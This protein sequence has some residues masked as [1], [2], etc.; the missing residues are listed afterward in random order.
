MHR[1]YQIITFLILIA[2]ID[3]AIWSQKFDSKKDSLSALLKADVEDTIKVMHL[4]ELGWELMYQNPDTAIIIGNQ[5]VELANSISEDKMAQ[6]NPTFKKSAYRLLAKSNNYLGI[7]YWVKGE[8]VT[9]LATYYQALKIATQINDKRSAA[10]I[11]TNI[12][13][14]FK[15]Q[16]DYPKALEYYLKALGMLKETGAKSVE[17]ICLGNIGNVYIAQNDYT[18]ALLYYN[19]AYTINKE[20]KNSNLMAVNLNNIGN[21]YNRQKTY[22]KALEYYYQALTLYTELENLSGMGV[23]YGNIG[24]IYDKKRD[25]QPALDSYI[26]AFDLAK[27]VNDQ[28]SISKWGGCI[29]TVYTEL[30][31]YKKAE[32]YLTAALTL[33][34]QLEVLDLVR[35][36]H[37]ELSNLYAVTNRSKLAYE[38]HLKYTATKD[39]LFNDEKS[40]DIGKLE[41]KY[42]LENAE[43]ERVR[44]LEEEMKIKERNR[45]RKNQLQYSGIVVI[46]LI[47]GVLV[48]ILGFV[49]VNPTIA[50]GIS[51]FAFLLLFEFLILLF[52]PLIDKYSSGEP[53]YKLLFNAIIA[54]CVFPAHAFFE[55]TIRRKLTRK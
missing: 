15:D 19:E 53:A 28:H 50:S 2:G 13:N 24:N 52:D 12:A 49:K 20:L 44:K 39:S 51:F 1:I 22:S 27:K 9:A 32:E 18:N 40:K 43:K 4:N 14:V 25:F 35:D 47:I 41:V 26:K 46:L 5:S 16:G 11:Y 7:F 29:G 37:L 33:S 38:H 30:K 36:H 23:I 42:E 10:S 8:Y 17:A 55:K 34:I 54:V 6:S 48:T 31:D 45:I 21:V 3:N